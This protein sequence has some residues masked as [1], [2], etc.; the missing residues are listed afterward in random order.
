[1]FLRVRKVLL[2]WLETDKAL[3]RACYHPLKGIKTVDEVL[4]ILNYYYDSALNNLLLDM[5][6]SY[7]QKITLINNWE[8]VA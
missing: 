2:W 6:Q 8:I 1:M 3:L 4:G 5:I 7:T